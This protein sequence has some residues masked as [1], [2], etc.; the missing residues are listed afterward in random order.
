MQI[1]YRHDFAAYFALNHNTNNVMKP[2][3]TIIL[4][5]PD[6]TSVLSRVKRVSHSKA[7]SSVEVSGNEALLDTDEDKILHLHDSIIGEDKAQSS[8]RR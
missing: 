8:R 1:L 6:K 2:A 7:T 3:K 4:Q 5:A